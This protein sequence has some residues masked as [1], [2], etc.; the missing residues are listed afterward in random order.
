MQEE[1]EEV[2][3]DLTE[4]VV[5]MQDEAEALVNMADLVEEYVDEIAI[6]EQSAEM[7]EWVSDLDLDS[8]LGTISS[9]TKKNHEEGRGSDRKKSHVRQ[10]STRIRHERENSGIGLDSESEI[11]P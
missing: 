6:A 4:L 11:D 8:L 10:P 1:E 2:L 9:P 7:Q 5:I 3:R